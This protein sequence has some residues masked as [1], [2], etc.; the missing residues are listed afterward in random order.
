MT[1]GD[2]ELALLMPQ[3]GRQVLLLGSVIMIAGFGVLAQ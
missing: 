3:I 2:R 1:V